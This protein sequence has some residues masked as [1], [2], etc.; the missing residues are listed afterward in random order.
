MKRYG[1]LVALVMG[2][3]GCNQYS[4]VPEPSGQSEDCIPSEIN[5][6]RVP[7][8]RFDGDDVI[9][10]CTACDVDECNSLGARCDVEGETCDFYGKLG[11]CRGC[12]DSEY[13][14]LHCALM[15]P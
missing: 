13:G 6:T 5:R 15:L 11:V 7:S 10:L 3:A 4:I 14:E 1:L 8:V 12:C 9:L 2:L